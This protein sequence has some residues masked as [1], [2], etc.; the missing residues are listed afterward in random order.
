MK[1]L[2]LVVVLAALGGGAV[3]MAREGMIPN[4]PG[5]GSDRAVLKRQSYRFLE[6]LKFKDFKAAAA[7]HSPE[8]LKA[9]PNIPKLL[10]DF[11]LIPPES[12][13]IQ[14][15]ALDFI[16]FDSSGN[17]AKVKTTTT[18]NILN[19]KETQKPEIMLYWNRQGL[20]W[21][22]DLRTTLER[23]PRH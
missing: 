9:N 6:C 22:L 11:F 21:Y 10:E 13:D 18:V 23:A 4:V 12:L 8:D 5:I 7:F 3:Y 16:D 19:K 14:D 1:K 17:R 2:L 15:I 20:K